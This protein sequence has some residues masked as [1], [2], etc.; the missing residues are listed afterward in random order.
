MCLVA[1][2]LTKT[3]ILQPED[4][5]VP[6]EFVGC[7]INWKEGKDVTVEQVG[8]TWKGAGREQGVVPGQGDC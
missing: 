4:D 5:I 2:V 6:K 8:S 1:Q 7:K 3:Y